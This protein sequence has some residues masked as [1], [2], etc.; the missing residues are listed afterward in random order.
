MSYFS[1]IKIDTI[2][3]QLGVVNK[4]FWEVTKMKVNRIYENSTRVGTR[5]DYN[6]GNK[7]WKDN[8]GKTVLTYRAN[9]N[10]YRDGT[11]KRVR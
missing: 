5:V 3:L 7:T 6:N 8:S 11:G 1:Y 10:S 9:D 2:R 4:I